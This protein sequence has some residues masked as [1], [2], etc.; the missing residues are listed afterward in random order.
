MH[1]TTL[2]TQVKNL[3]QGL[4][5]EKG[6]WVVCME[7][8]GG[9]VRLHTASTFEEGVLA[10]KNAHKR[11]APSTTT[12]PQP[13]QQQLAP[14]EKDRSL[15]PTRAVCE[16]CNCR[17]PRSPPSVRTAGCQRGDG[18]T[19][20]QAGHIDCKPG[21]RTR[22]WTQARALGREEDSWVLRTQKSWP[23]STPTS[24]LAEDVLV[25]GVVGFDA[26]GISLVEIALQPVCFESVRLPHLHKVSG[27]GRVVTRHVSCSHALTEAR[28]C[29]F[30]RASPH[31]GTNDRRDRTSSQSMAARQD[32][33]TCPA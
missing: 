19:R 31:L 17:A 30:A 7:G 25:A 10:Q 28:C 11:Q 32:R 12:K 23:S 5:E 29:P 3:W 15:T 24:P 16:M 9:G 4:G 8:R 14:P 1:V 33:Q 18:E 2:G 21:R 13:S 26:V 20:L 22:S 27:A 6:G